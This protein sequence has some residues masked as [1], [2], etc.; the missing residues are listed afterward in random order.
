[1][2]LH[3]TTFKHLFIVSIFVLFDVRLFAATAN[4]TVTLTISSI[5]S[6][7][8]SGNPA[9]LL[10]NSATAGNDLNNA[11][12]SSTTYAVSTNN[13]SR[14]VTA[15][16]AS[17]MPTGLTLSIQATAPSGGTSTGSVSMSTTAAALVTGISLIANSGLSL[18][19]TL[20]ATLTATQVTNATNTVTYTIGP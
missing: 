19:Y 17:A 13:S 9:T 1:M 20:A 10:V 3:N 8:V 15:S 5:D 14:R 16:I 6:I 7:S 4:A 2:C 12:D 18:T 11:T